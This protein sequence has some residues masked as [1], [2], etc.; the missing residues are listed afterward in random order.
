MTSDDGRLLL[1]RTAPSFADPASG[2]LAKEQLNRALGLLYTRQADSARRSDVLQLLAE[3]AETEWESSAASARRTFIGSLFLGQRVQLSVCV[4]CRHASAAGA[5]PYTVETVHPPAAAARHPV[6]LASLLQGLG[7]GGGG[8]AGGESRGGWATSS[9]DYN[10]PGCGKLGTTCSRSACSRL[11][12][13]LVVRINRIKT[14]FDAAGQLVESRIST[15]VSIPEYID[16]AGQMIADPAAAID[17]SGASC[18][19]VYKLNAAIFHR[20]QTTRSGHYTAWVRSVSPP[21]THNSH[22][23]TTTTHLAVAAIWRSQRAINAIW[24]CLSRNAAGALPAAMASAESVQAAHADSD[25]TVTPPPSPSPPMQRSREFPPTPSS[26][27]LV[28]ILVIIQTVLMGPPAFALRP[29]PSLTTAAPSRP[30]WPPT[31]PTP[32]R[33]PGPVR[34]PDTLPTAVLISDLSSF[35]GLLTWG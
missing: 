28:I 1:E 7:G 4:A 34:D 25:Q 35:V 24:V 18:G 23:H 27:D 31:R 19:T 29:G 20:G 5:E 22:T 14:G 26:D 32:S 11:P 12:E 15:P 2:S 9:W 3:F 17:Y 13:N 10:C 16:L 8:V 30:A 33:T 21:H 6:E